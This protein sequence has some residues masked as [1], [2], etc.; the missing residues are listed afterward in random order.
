MSA[1]IS[2]EPNS[3]KPPVK[4]RAYGLFPITRR[5]YAIVQT[6]CFTAILLAIA[7][8]EI[9]PP[10]TDAYRKLAAAAPETDRPPIVMFA[11]VLDRAQTILLAILGLGVV[12]TVWMLRKFKAAETRDA[13]STPSG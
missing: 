1:P 3:Q 8:V 11:K 4:I 10:D 6:C 13:H 2:S 5:G 9:A 7:W 12:E